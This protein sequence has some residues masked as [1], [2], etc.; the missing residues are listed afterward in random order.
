MERCKVMD[1]AQ[2]HIR[3]QI[4]AL[5]EQGQVWVV[6][7]LSSPQPQPLVI[8][9]GALSAK[10]FSREEVDEVLNLLFPATFRVIGSDHLET[11]DIVR[12]AWLSQKRAVKWTLALEA[13][14]YERRPDDHWGEDG[15]GGWRHPA[16]KT[17]KC[18]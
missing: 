8:L 9:S 6:V 18:D 7:M 11:T 13:E 4:A 10:F 12:G 1:P 17:M 16:T 3:K 15:L 14:L 5:E 2:L